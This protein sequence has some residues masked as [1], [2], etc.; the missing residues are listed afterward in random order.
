MGIAQFYIIRFRPWVKIDEDRSL[1]HR[2]VL[3]ESFEDALQAVR[4]EHP[5]V[6]ITGASL[7]GEVHGIPVLNAT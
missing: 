5:E 2:H 7:Q 4:E 6:E 3:A 1:G